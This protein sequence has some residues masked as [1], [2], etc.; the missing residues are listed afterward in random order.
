[1]DDLAGKSSEELV[2]L[3]WG[4]DELV[5]LAAIRELRAELLEREQIL[6]GS[7]R[8]RRRTWSEIGEALGTTRQ[9]AY[10]RFCDK[11]KQYDPSGVLGSYSE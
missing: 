3:I 7:A 8:V 5:G 6:V 1:M 4:S 10:N 11:V 9:G 2:G